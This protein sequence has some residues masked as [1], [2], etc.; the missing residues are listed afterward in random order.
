MNHDIM[1]ECCSDTVGS[2]IPVIIFPMTP[3]YPMDPMFQQ[4]SWQPQM[5]PPHT[6]TLNNDFNNF[7]LNAM[8]GG[9]Y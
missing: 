3:N 1:C 9:M 8:G 4:A 7:N 5:M 2:S 6:L